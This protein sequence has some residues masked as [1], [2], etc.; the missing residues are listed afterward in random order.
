MKTTLK[1][2]TAAAVAAIMAGT[3]TIK[4]GAQSFYGSINYGYTTTFTPVV[5]YEPVISYQ[6]CTYTYWSYQYSTYNY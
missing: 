3:S 6:P 5:Q 2:L 4:A 1:V